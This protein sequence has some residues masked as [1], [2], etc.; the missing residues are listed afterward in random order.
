MY[1]VW[2]LVAGT[3]GIFFPY[4][5]GAVGSTTARANLVLQAIWF[6][7]T[8]LAVAFVYMPLIDRVNR[9][10]MLMWSTALQLAAFIPF[11]FF[12]VTFLTALI[13]V[14]LFGAW[15]TVTLPALERRAVPHAAAKHGP[16]LHVRRGA[17]RARRMDPATA[18]V[19]KWGFHTLSAI[20]FAM[21]FVS[22]LVGIL[23]APDTTGRDLQE[24]QGTAT[25]RRPS[26]RFTRVEEKSPSRA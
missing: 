16:G 3:Y 19:E 4:I 25:G 11:I 17:H 24:T 22:G 13:N 12:H 7:S 21:L 10:T 26:G 20:L 8:V 2:G 18:L 6:V 1:G 23:F 14:V 15:A 5:L 9:R